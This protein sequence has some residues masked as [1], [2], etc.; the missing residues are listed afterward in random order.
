MKAL[1]LC[2]GKGT[3]LSPYTNSS[4]KALLDV[5]GN[6]ILGYI[7]KTLAKH[8]IQ[9]IALN[10]HYLPESIQDYCQQ[11]HQDLRLHFS[12]ENKILGTAGALTPLES[13]LTEN[14]DDFLVHY[15]DVLCDHNLNKLIDL[16]TKN[17][18]FATLLVHKNPESNSFLYLN[19][20]QRV[21]SFYE[22][23]SLEE[24]EKLIQQHG[25]DFW[26]NS[27]IQILNRDVFSFIKQK[28]AFDLCRDVYSELYK[29][30]LLLGQPLE[31]K[32][33]AIDSLERLE[34]ARTLF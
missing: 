16:H 24:K 12:L 28:K 26:A 34:L 23:P 17:K 14:D 9:D 25:Q 15:G 29:E 13:W 31:G 3:R 21:T 10:L 7:L 5:N 22:R 4:P 8:G 18:A 1:V 6:P 11:H 2:A 32:R 19:N 30:K 20:Q 33:V 27:G